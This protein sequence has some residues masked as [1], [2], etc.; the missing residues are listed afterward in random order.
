[1][2]E[3]LLAKEGEGGNLRNS[4]RLQE[5]KLLLGDEANKS[6]FSGNFHRHRLPT[7]V[8]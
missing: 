8:G 2:A 6:T 5:A 1:M 3:T 4:G 7:V